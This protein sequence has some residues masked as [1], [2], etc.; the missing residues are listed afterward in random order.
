MSKPV[1]DRDEIYSILKERHG[2]SVTKSMRRDLALGDFRLFLAGGGGGARDD[3]DGTMP[4]QA[5]SS[6][7]DENGRTGTRGETT[8]VQECP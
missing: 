1:L 5:V 6:G 7:I 2:S 8:F 4:C 3:V